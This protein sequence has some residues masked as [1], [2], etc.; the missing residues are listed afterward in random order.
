MY[1]I[2][3]FADPPD[4]KISGDQTAVEGY[5]VE[6]QCENEDSFPHELGNVTWQK[7]GEILVIGTIPTWA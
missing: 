1:Y 5:T 6:I 2:F 7:D 4:V 3:D